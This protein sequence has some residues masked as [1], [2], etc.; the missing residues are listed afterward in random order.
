MGLF[1]LLRGYAPIGPEHFALNPDNWTPPLSDPMFPWL[2]SP[3]WSD[4]AGTARGLGVT[5]AGTSTAWDPQISSADLAFNPD[6]GAPF[7]PALAPARPLSVS[8]YD[9]PNTGARFGL[10]PAQQ[11]IRAT[12]FGFFPSVADSTAAYPALASWPT[13]TELPPTS[14]GSN[15]TRPGLD[16][17]SSPQRITAEDFLLFASGPS[18]DATVVDQEPGG[19]GQFASPGTSEIPGTQLAQTFLPPLAEFFLQK[20]PVSPLPPRGLTPLEELPPGSSG[21]PNA[22]KLFPRSLNDKPEGTPCR[23]CGTPTTREPGPDQYNGDHIFPR[24]RGGNSDP[25]NHLDSCRTCNLRKGPRTP[26]EWYESL[27]GDWT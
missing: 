1:D 17:G 13:A 26:R 25:P 11:P 15:I 16:H 23:Y 4:A 3:T 10:S 9:A 19:I 20:P 18:S 2:L 6:N 24:G 7:L 12:N 14:S 8:G 5:P 21:G 27:G 22:E